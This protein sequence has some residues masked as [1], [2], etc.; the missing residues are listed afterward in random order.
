MITTDQ[1]SLWLGH[2][3][4]ETRKAI[5]KLNIQMA[6]DRTETL[7]VFKDETASQVASRFLGEMGLNEQESKMLEEHIIDRVIMKPWDEAALV[8]QIKSFL[9]EQ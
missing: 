3:E 5:M 6:A 9:A 4:V 7:M 2:Q 1:K 8:S